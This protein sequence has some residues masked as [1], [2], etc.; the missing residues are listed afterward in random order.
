MTQR[1]GHRPAGENDEAGNDAEDAGEQEQPTRLCPIAEAEKDANEPSRRKN[2]TQH[3]GQEE[4]A[5]DRLT[6]KNHSRGD[7]E[8]SEQNLPNEAAPALR[9]K[10]VNDLEHAADDRAKAD[11][12]R[13]DDGGEDD[14]AEHKDAGDNEDYTE[15]K[16]QPDRLRALG[17]CRCG[18]HHHRSLLIF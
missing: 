15:K 12:D 14:V 1:P 18:I 5:G 3:P 7:I 9:P 4:G 2:D 17:R 10:R 6:E 11:E 8:K 16:T 13:A